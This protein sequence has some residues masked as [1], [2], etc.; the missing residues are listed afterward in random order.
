NFKSW[1]LVPVTLFWLQVLSLDPATAKAF[2]PQEKTILD[3]APADNSRPSSPEH[4]P[5]PWTNS[6]VPQHQVSPPRL[7]IT[8]PLQ[9]PLHLTCCASSPGS[10]STLRS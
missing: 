5:P 3:K 8:V 4:S 2:K 10:S 7:H 6:L 9:H 1:S